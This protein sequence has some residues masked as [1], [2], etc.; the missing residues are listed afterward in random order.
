ME[1]TD[2]ALLIHFLLIRGTDADAETDAEF[3]VGFSF[4]EFFLLLGRNDLSFDRRKS[5]TVMIINGSESGQYCRLPAAASAA[6][7]CR[8]LL[9]VRALMESPF[10]GLAENQLFVKKCRK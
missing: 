5:W 7:G 6:F 1:R 9:A 3:S 8:Q 10:P 2:P 4:T